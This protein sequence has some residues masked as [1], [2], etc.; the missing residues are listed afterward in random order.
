MAIVQSFRIGPIN[1]MG[2]KRLNN[3]SD[4]ARQGFNLRVVCRA[5]G[6]ASVIDARALTAKCAEAS[7]SLNMN[8]VQRRLKCQSCNGREVVCGPVEAPDKSAYNP[9]IKSA[10]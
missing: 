6:R 10:P 5:C 7:L 1:R 8:A 9:R 2:S 4:Y 3:I